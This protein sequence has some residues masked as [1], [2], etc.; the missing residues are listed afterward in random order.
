MLVFNLNQLLVESYHANTYEIVLPQKTI[1]ISSVN[2][3]FLSCEEMEMSLCV[4]LTLIFHYFPNKLIKVVLN[5]FHVKL[6][7]TLQIQTFF[8]NFISL[9]LWPLNF[10]KP[11]S[12]KFESIHKFNSI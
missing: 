10:L 12:Y 5:L 11:M 2:N 9:F 6:L 7:F 1:L 4:C 3:Y 8:Y